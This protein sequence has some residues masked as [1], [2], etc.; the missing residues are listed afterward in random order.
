MI[1]H[2]DKYL[3]LITQQYGLI[4]YAILFSIIFIETG[5]VIMP[6]LPGDSML[7]AAGAISAIG[8][9][10]IFTLLIVIYIA[11][12]LGDTCNYYIGRKIGTNILEK[13]ST[14]YINKKYL[15]KAQDFYKKH[16]SMTIVL[17]RFIPIVRTFAPFVAGIGEMKYSKFIIYNIIG[18]GLWVTL[19]LSGGYF[20]GNL[21]PVKNNFSYVLIS[22]IIISLIPGITV[23]IK[24]KWKRYI[25]QDNKSNI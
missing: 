3:N 11:A 24:E 4:T 13:E 17:A 23:V 5:L 10:N 21:P 22:I 6:F 14:K 19:F 1:M 25:N 2:I 8:S 15:D 16:G 18:G 9:L 7:F 20:F 12:V